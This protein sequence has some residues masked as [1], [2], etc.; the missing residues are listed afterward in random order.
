M[1]V[2]SG[3][4]TLPR[5]G[6]GVGTA[7]QCRFEESRLE[8]LVVGLNHRT[9]PLEV[10]ER[11]S[12]SAGRLPDALQ[13]MSRCGMPGVILSTC[14]RS[15]FYALDPPSADG[16]SGHW[17]A[18]DQR[19]REFLVDYFG[20]S[21]VDV[22]RYL[23]TYQG[24][25][26]INHLFRVASSL[27]SMM[28]G[29]D[30]IIGQVREAFDLALQNE[31]IRGPLFPLFQ[32]ALRVGRR[33]RRE[34]G[35]GRN[36]VSVSRACVEL[37]K[38][39]LGDLKG[40]RA[41]VVGA[42]D[43][44]GLAA[45]VLSMSGV[46][47]ITVTN[48]TYER[49]KEMA[50]LLSGP[51]MRPARAVPFGDMAQALRHA[52]LVIACTGSPGFVLDADTVSQAMRDRPNEPMF[53][54]DIA[55]P[56]DIDPKAGELNSVVLHDMDDLEAISESRRLEKAQ[57]TALAEELVAKETEDFLEWSLTQQALPTVIALRDRAEMIR[58]GEMAKT[59]KK[60][61]VDLSDEQQEALEAMT[62]AI[63]KKML[64]GPTVYLKK[65]RSPSDL[66]T[67][68]QMFQIEVP[69]SRDSRL[70]SR[71]RG[72]DDRS[73]GSDDRSGRDDDRSGG[74]H[75]GGRPD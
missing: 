62:R 60:L 70:D 1:I 50:R 13:A 11:L 43:A 20:I 26:C 32:Q 35:I 44:G 69:P 33:V 22:E 29:E 64:H 75:A 19:T 54:I 72:N 46:Q 10:R 68:Q 67:A 48:R 36:A 4:I 7:P 57:E 8:F 45:K 61:D 28:L 30:Q 31:T 14:N 53:M 55:V 40:R 63:V 66:R 42:G 15:E 73:G 16:I 65:H 47:D 9:A 38:S 58:S 51:A 6:T 52:D 23:Y 18:G 56:R 37:A 3:N 39:N 25:E 21:L 74:N 27:D 49:A 24:H 34:T 12:L 71:L 41:M 17:G 2:Y 59:L 5:I